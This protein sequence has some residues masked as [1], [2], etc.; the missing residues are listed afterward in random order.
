MASSGALVIRFIGD[1][2]DFSRATAQT[3]SKLSKF[4]SGVDRVGRVAGK[5]LGIGLLAGGAAMVKLTKAAA[6]DEAAQTRLA[7]V[8]KNTTGASKAQIAATE[9][10]ITAQGKATGITDDELRP[11]LARLTAATGAVG[12]A[13]RLATL[14]QDVAAGT[15]KSYK[16]VTEALAK[17]Q[18]GNISGLSRL[19]IKTTD[20]TGKT[21]SLQQITKDLAG[22]YGGTAAKAAETAAGKQKILTTQL[23]ELGEQIGAAVLPAM[24]RMVEIGLKMTAWV[25]SHTKLVGVLVGVLATFAAGL[26]AASV[27][28]RA[29]STIV[30]VAQAVAKA[31]TAVQWL[32]NAA[33]NANPISIVVLA[34]AALVAAVIIAYKKS[35]TFRAIVDAAFRA[36]GK[37]GKWMWEN[38]LKPA[39]DK[40]VLAIKALG[41]IGRWLWNN[42][43]QPVFQFLVRGIAT[44]LEMWAK[45][46]STLGKVPG[47]GWAKEAAKKMQGAADKANALADNIKKI[48]DHK[49]VNVNVKYNYSGLKDPTRGRGGDPGLPP[50]TSRGGLAPRGRGFG[51][52]TSGGTVINA[53]FN[54]TGD[55]YANAEEVRRALLRLK[56]Q[57][58]GGDLGL[59]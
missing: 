29:W 33:L 57:L 44:I 35:D 12:K 28:I 56:R 53:T 18:N 50:P 15:G 38:A 4:S 39:F 59:A 9:R 8:L 1:T 43:F 55:P 41:K 47:F 31:W 24:S 19:G 16:S 6:E 52:S 36:I 49:N 51:G 10:W 48:P 20:A 30:K 42:V 21:K 23:G 3:Q 37:A 26:Y 32:L 17:A 7:N 45:M 40:M 13:Q 46:L 58:G 34:I 14:A 27:A 5:A 25:S 54:L 22:T 11:A 2:R